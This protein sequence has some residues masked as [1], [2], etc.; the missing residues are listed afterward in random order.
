MGKKAKG[1]KTDE[2]QP[3]AKKKGKGKKTDKRAA[4]TE[5]HTPMVP[6]M[7]D[8]L[9]QGK[10]QVWFHHQSLQGGR[11]YRY[12]V[13]VI[14]LNPLYGYRQE[15]KEGAEKDAEIPTIEAPWS[16]WSEPTRVVNPTEFYVSGASGSQKTVKVDVFALSLGQRVRQRFTVQEGG[17]IGGSGR[18]RVLDPVTGKEV[19]RQVA[20]D[21]GSLAV[22]FEFN[23][24]IYKGQGLR[25]TETVAIVYLDGQGDLLARTYAEDQHSDHYKALQEEADHT[26]K[27]AQGG[28]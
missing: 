9:A 26:A 8:Q 23:R 24:I 2:P 18:V 1:K 5:V 3:P 12:R 28:K 6:S 11:A 21:T 27:R 10:V 15:V 4:E 19:Q 7:G 14:V 16:P 22:R 25:P 13:R 20:F 17:R